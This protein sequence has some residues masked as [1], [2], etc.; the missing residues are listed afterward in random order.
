M[1]NLMPQILLSHTIKSLLTYQRLGNMFS[2][3]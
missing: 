2:G 1:T 3:E